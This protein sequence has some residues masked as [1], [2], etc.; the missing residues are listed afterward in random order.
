MIFNIF[1]RRY[2]SDGKLFDKIVD[3]ARSYSSSYSAI[4]GN[5]PVMAMRLSREGCD[6]LLAAKMTNSLKLMLPDDI[7][8]VGGEVE[9]DDVHLILE[10]KDGETWG[11]YTSA[12]ANRYIIHNDENNPMIS[13]LEEFDN[14]LPAF[15]PDLFIV[16]GLQMMDN[17][18]FK[19]G[20]R[21]LRLNKIKK[22]MIDQLSTTKVHFEM[23]SFVEKNMLFELQDMILPF[24]DSIGMNEQEAANLYNT[25]YY[26]NVSLIA[27]STP[28]VATI[29]DYMRTLFKLI[30]DNNKG[31]EGSRKL[32]RIHVHTLAYQ[33]IL[34]VKNSIWKNTMAAAAKASLVAHRH[35]CGTSNVCKFFNLYF[36]N[37]MIKYSS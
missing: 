7:K 12:R 11:P 4:G 23:A 5:A 18:P 9:R 22:Q 24:T 3:K 1:S 34:T 32:T 31:I 17:Y 8:V 29:L 30:R 15:K 35:V 10:Y 14:I 6:V 26:G 25:I 20:T 37:I 13:S 28:R 33:A 19:N 16:G 21:K 2:M 27:D 36:V